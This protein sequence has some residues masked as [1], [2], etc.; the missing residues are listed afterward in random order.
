MKI[1]KDGSVWD[2]VLVT[3]KAGAGLAALAAAA[4]NWGLRRNTAL[5]RPLWLV[6]GLL[7]VFP[8][9]LEALMERLT[10]FDVPHPAPFGL[11]IAAALLLKQ[12]MTRRGAALPA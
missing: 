1:P 9:L 6:A 5:E 2:I 10:G 8:S 12:Y 7:L 3:A 11:A 4:Q